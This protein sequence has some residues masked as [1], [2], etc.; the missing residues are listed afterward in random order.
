MPKSC[1]AAMFE[2]FVPLAAFLRPEKRE[3]EMAQEAVPEPVHPDIEDAVAAAR[4]FRAALSDALDVAVMRLLREI[5]TNVLGRELATSHADVAAV[6]TAALA[7]LEDESVL[8]IRANRDDLDALAVFA[9]ECVADSRLRR[10]E[11]L[12]EVKSGTIDQRFTARL[13]AAV[14]ACAP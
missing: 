11:V 8:V 5:S 7:R 14:A 4:R 1:F 6:V 13:E 2:R 9:I 10:G 3:I 12:F